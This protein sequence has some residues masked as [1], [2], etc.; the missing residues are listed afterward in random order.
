MSSNLQSPSFNWKRDDALA[1]A[2][3][4]V[5]SILT[6]LVMQLPFFSSKMENKVI[7]QYMVPNEHG[8]FPELDRK[9][10]KNGWTLKQLHPTFS[11]GLRKILVLERPK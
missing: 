3:G 10:L 2:G 4:I 11:T 6:L 1:L 5:G 9:Y 8:E 7:E